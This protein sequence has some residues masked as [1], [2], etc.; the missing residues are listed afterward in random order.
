[1]KRL[2]YLVTRSEVGGAQVHV[3]QLLR[4][5]KARFDVHVAVGDEGFLTREAR[6]LGVEVHV[7]PALVQPISPIRDLAAIWST[8]KLLR[9][10]RPSLVHAHSSKAGLVGRIAAVQTGVP[11][12]FTAHGWAF[13]EGVPP[14]RRL[15]AIL[16]ERTAARWADRIITVSEQDRMLALRYGVGPAS[17]LV[18][19]Y[20]G[21]ADIPLQARPA[22]G[23]DAGNEICVIMVAR[24][25][26]QKD[27]SLL[28]RA[29]A[30]VQGTWRLKLVGEG[31]TRPQVESLVRSLG[32]QERVEFLGARQDV[33]TLLAGAHVFV[34]TSNWEGF[35]LSILEAMRAGLPVIASDVGGVREA[36]LEGITGFL[37]PRGNELILRNRLELI[38]ADSALRL[39]MGQAGRQHYIAH[40][41]TDTMVSRILEVYMQVLSPE[42]V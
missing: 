3:L 22:A 9:T 11:A 37:V 13:A 19:I 26:P 7:L 34:L 14:G 21:V 4:A 35:P 23:N 36:V 12:V 5:L 41:T 31:P 38:L 16:A 25:S 29:L 32:L 15:L 39:R 28:I 42:A 1:M 17:K 8:L 40:F 10:L 6:C 30:G 18:T 2:L 33:P 24:F 27:H 20:N